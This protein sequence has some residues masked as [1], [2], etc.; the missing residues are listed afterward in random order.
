MKK[1]ENNYEES[2]SGTVEDQEPGTKVI[3]RPENLE[4][5]FLKGTLNKYTPSLTNNNFFISRFLVLTNRNFIYYKNEQR[6]KAFTNQSANSRWTRPA[7]VNVPLSDI[8]K[9]VAIPK[10]SDL[11]RDETYDSPLYAFSPKSKKKQKQDENEYTDSI[12]E[13]IVKPDTKYEDASV[14]ASPGLKL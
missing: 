7:L 3:E 2:E 9:A 13:I 12:F 1:S 4:S 8:E 14:F 11:H 6:Y 10:L 5:V